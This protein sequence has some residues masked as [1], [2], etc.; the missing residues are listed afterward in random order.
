MPNPANVEKRFTFGGEDYV[1]VFDWEAIAIFEDETNSSIF[2]ILAPLTGGSP[3]LSTMAMMLKAGLARHHPDLTRADAMAM[4][5]DPEVQALFNSGVASMMPQ[6]GDTDDGATEGNRKA[7][8]KPRG[9]KRGA[10]KQ[11]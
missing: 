3:K 11:S 9:G 1:L 6:A 2:D 8:R 10:G 4:L 5:V 7:S